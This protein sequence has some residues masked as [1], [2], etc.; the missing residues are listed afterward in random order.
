MAGFRGYPP[1]MRFLLLLL[2]AVPAAA[3]NILVVGDSHTAGAFGQNLDDSL[4]ADVNSRVATYGVCSA[5]PESYLSETAHGC[6]WLFRGPDK[7]APAKWLGGRVTKVKQKNG[8]GEEVLVD[9]VKTPELAQLIA[10]HTPDVVVVALGSNMPATDASIDKVLELVH[11]S[12]ASCF[13]VGPP[14]MRKPSRKA[15]NGVYRQLDDR[16]ITVTASL[17]DACRLI[18]SRDFTYLRY[19]KEGGDATHYNGELAG[20]AARWGKE[21]A[22]AIRKA[23]AP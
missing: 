11:K 2:L 22:A 10:D 14:D 20:M 8:K 23:L 7:K 17:K 21:T 19:P 15:V 16:G 13:W 1:A 9:Y 18:D 3:G 5:R 4:R 12:G 6:G